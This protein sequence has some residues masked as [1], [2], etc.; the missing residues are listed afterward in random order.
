VI[1]EPV[2]HQELAPGPLYAL[3]A[4]AL[5]FG[6]TR[7]PILLVSSQP[8]WEYVLRRRLGDRFFTIDDPERPPAQA[9]IGAAWLDPQ[10]PLWQ[11][12]LQA[13]SR[14]LPGGSLLSVV[15]SLPLAALRRTVNPYAVGIVP[16]RLLQFRTALIQNGFRL[17]RTF[18]F[19]TLWWIV[20]GRIA[21]RLETTR[22]DLGD[23]LHF[24][25]R[26]GFATRGPALVFAMT[27]LIEARAGMRPG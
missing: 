4:C 24:A 19:Q 3:D 14:E 6:A 7:G 21:A 12:Q 9:W 23:R 26:R 27:G 18:G 25:M 17:E 5:S 15:Q 22:P 13:M 2:V 8:A 20:L 1:A 16:H 10:R 11:G